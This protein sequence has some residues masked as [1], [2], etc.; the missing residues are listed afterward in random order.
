[1]LIRDDFS[2][3]LR[4]EVRDKIWKNLHKKS[5]CHSE[6]CEESKMNSRIITK[7]KINKAMKIATNVLRAFVV[8]YSGGGRPQEG[9]RLFTHCILN[10]ILF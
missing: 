9:R 5:L 1:M 10:K 6:L 7:Q 2:F 8:F 3:F 4:L